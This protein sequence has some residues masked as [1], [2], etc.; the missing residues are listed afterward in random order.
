MFNKPQ[1]T[2]QRDPPGLRLQC[3]LKTVGDPALPLDIGQQLHGSPW[4]ILATVVYSKHSG[5]F[6][7]A[8]WFY[9]ILRCLTCFAMEW[10]NN[11]YTKQELSHWPGLLSTIRCAE[12]NIKAS[13]MV[14][15]CCFP[16]LLFKL[17]FFALWLSKLHEISLVICYFLARSFSRWD[18]FPQIRTQSIRSKLSGKHQVL[19]STQATTIRFVLIP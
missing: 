16:L 15:M 19:T 8:L 2:R 4:Q 5:D 7:V 1:Q 6:G 3:C 10:K 12:Q 9:M 17:F 14:F 11:L 13:M 18:A